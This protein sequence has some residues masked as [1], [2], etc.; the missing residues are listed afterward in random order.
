M[1]PPARCS[2]ESNLPR[3]GRSL[4]YPTTAGSYYDFPAHSSAA[5]YTAS[6][7]NYGHTYYGHTSSPYYYA[8]IPGSAPPEGGHFLYPHPFSNIHPAEQQVQMEMEIEAWSENT[9]MSICS[10]SGDL[11]ESQVNIEQLDQFCKYI[12]SSGDAE[13][14]DEK[15]EKSMLGPSESEYTCYSMQS[16]VRRATP[17]PKKKRR[18]SCAMPNYYEE[19]QESMEGMHEWGVELEN[20]S[21]WREFDSVGTEMVIT[22][23]G[24]LALLLI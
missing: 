23:A 2:S 11:L 14:I 3:R 19:D 24:R 4:S 12:D 5:A 8:A 1:D 7:E 21:M 13:F 6:S 15:G 16:G 17:P 22:K 10:G 9:A 18:S 20:S